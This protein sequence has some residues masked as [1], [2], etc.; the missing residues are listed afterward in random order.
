MTTYIQ[1]EVRRSTELWMLLALVFFLPLYEAPKNIFWL[2]Y[3]VVWVYNRWRC[4]DWG[5]PWGAWDTMISTWM[6]SGYVV[7]MFAGTHG[8]EWQGAA[9]LVRYGS[10]LWCIRRSE[11]SSSQLIRIGGMVLIGCVIAL[12]WGFWRYYITQERSYV[13]LHS[14]GHV[15][16]SAPYL[17]ICAGLALSFLFAFWQRSS[18]GLR[19]LAAM[20]LSFVLAGLVI[21]SSRG[22]IG[23]MAA[24]MVVLGIAWR[25]RSVVPLSIVVVSLV[26]GIVVATAGNWAVVEKQRFGMKTG[27]N[28]SQRGTIWN[29]AIVA[30]QA[31]PWFGVGID[32]FGMISDDMLRR[33]VESRGKAYVREEYAGPNH[34]HSLYFN[35]LAERGVF[36]FVVL[37]TALI[38]WATTLWRHRPLLAKSDLEWTYW[39]GAV[40][41]WIVIVGAGFFNT[42]L[43]HEIALLAMLV[44]GAWM[45]VERQGKASG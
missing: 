19:L 28:L 25:R 38:A 4:G 44:L 24:A 12:A 40:S 13:E 30:W 14:V 10:I 37:M 7:A 23:A 42:T 5:G 39:G 45:A 9:D 26:A 8:T 41:G 34:A 2:A 29:R 11:Y 18:N 22:A 15:N 36:G 31:N 43:H 6:A 21:G 1:M 20:V 33:Q 16:H 35:T 17:A 27:D 3:V 32:N